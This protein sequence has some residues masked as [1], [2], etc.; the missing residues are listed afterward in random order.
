MALLNYH[1]RFAEWLRKARFIMNTAVTR[2]DIMQDLSEIV[3]YQDT[4][5][6]LF[7][8][9]GILSTYP[10]LRALC[11]W[12][13]DLEF[14]RMRKGQMNYHVNGKDILLRE[15]DCI[16]VNARQMHY[17]YS[18]HRQDCEFLCILFHPS[19]FTSNKRLFRK[20]IA[21]VT[22][23]E[24]IEYL[25]FD[26]QQDYGREAAAYMDFIF[27]KWEQNA[28]GAE[29]EIIGAMHSFWTKIYNR[30]QEF[31]QAEH[32]PIP[33][34]LSAQKDMVCYIYLHYMEKITLD[35]IAGAGNV[36]RSKCCSIFKHYLQQSPIDFLNAYRLKVSSNLLKETENSVTQIALMCGFN[37]LSYYSRL[38]CKTYG[39][40]P[41][42]Y[43]SQN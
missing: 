9:Y 14:I 41:S 36:C 35:D 2:T 30:C 12:H 22:E 31:F 17:G 7:I 43:R 20:Y 27:E 37:H 32:Q 29:F 8:K 25:Y 16:M 42:E 18:F 19:L 38:F 34:D 24:S 6:P 10:N 21:P 33:S 1:C 23:N 13:E 11:H 28:P 5:V 40:T 3:H 15:N 26:S 39:C 4:A